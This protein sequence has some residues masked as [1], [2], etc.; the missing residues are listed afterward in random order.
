[1]TFWKY[2]RFGFESFMVPMGPAWTITGRAWRRV[3]SVTVLHDT[4]AR[5]GGAWEIP[6]EVDG[7]PTTIAA[8]RLYQTCK[9]ATAER[10]R[11]MADRHKAWLRSQWRNDVVKARAA[12]ERAERRRAATDCDC[13]C[14]DCCTHH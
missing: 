10:D 8:G 13:C 7:V 3:T 12:A 6:V 2:S 14:L 9:E 11:L 4:W 5:G 1:M